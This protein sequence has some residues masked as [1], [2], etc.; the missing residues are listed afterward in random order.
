MRSVGFGWGRVRRVLVVAGV[1]AAGVV[2][3]SGPAS[4]HV[5]V[6]SSDAA[7]GG[8]AVV[9]FRVPTEKEDASTV[10]LKV[11]LPTDQPLAFV[12]V[13]P[14][15][16]WTA[17]LTKVKLAT[18]IESDDGPVTEAVS[19][20]DWKVD[21]GAKG[22]APGQYDEFSVSVGPLP[23]VASMAFKAIQVYSDRSQVEWI[24][25]T[26]AG[27]A[28]PEHPAPVLELAAATAEGVHGAGAAT[29]Q[30]AAAA[31]ADNADAASKGAVLAALVIGGLGLAAGLAGL[32]FGVTSRRGVRRDPVAP[33]G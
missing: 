10:E 16:G 3:V 8:S 6:N 20:I 22:I 23:K 13:K 1:T 2:L 14:H 27:G 5:S 28:E 31:P 30:P 19:V 29:T 4:A 25:D 7:Q 17:T 15:P 18:P 33:A 11:Q 24:E 26:P 21:P 9:N 32:A 12:A